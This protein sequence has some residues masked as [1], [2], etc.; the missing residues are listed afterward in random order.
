MT[1]TVA[2]DLLPPAGLYTDEAE[3][4]QL[5]QLIQLFGSQD[6]DVAARSSPQIPGEIVG[7]GIAAAEA[8]VLYAQLS[9]R[10]CRL[11]S[12]IDDLSRG[13][14]PDVVLI[15][16]KY[17]TASLLDAL[18]SVNKANAPGI[19]FGRDSTELMNQVRLRAT[20]ARL[21]PCVGGLRTDVYP[22]LPFKV[23][24]VGSHR[25]FGSKV[26]RTT[27]RKA[28]GQRNGLLTI[29]THTDGIDALLG[30]T[31]MLCPMARQQLRATASKEPSCY[32]NKTCHR[33]PTSLSKVASH[34]AFMAP[35]D[36]RAGVLLWYG[37]LGVLT[38]KSAVDPQWGLALRFLNSCGIGA[39][40]TTWEIVF[41]SA[42]DVGELSERIAEG[43]PVGKAVAE[44]NAS[45]IARRKGLRLC[46]LGD[47]NVSI[48]SNRDAIKSM[49][50]V[51]RGA[52]SIQSRCDLRIPR[53][54]LLGVGFLRAC[55]ELR[56]SSLRGEIARL[57]DRAISACNEYEAA[58]AESR[59]QGSRA[60]SAERKMRRAML[61]YWFRRGSMISKDWS[62]ST[63]SL[64]LINFSVPCFNCGE[65]CKVLLVSFGHAGELRRRC[66]LCAN[67]EIIYDGPEED[68]VS[69]RLTI[70]GDGAL[71][72]E[73]WNPT[74]A[75]SCG[76]M[77]DTPLER[78]R[79]GW[80]WPSD[81]DGRPV[82]KFV[83]PK[84]LPQGPL[85]VSCFMI[86]GTNVSVIRIPTR[87]APA[88]KKRRGSEVT[89][90]DW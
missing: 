55:I 60:E 65:P 67:C 58:I 23:L 8:T 14:P 68:V 11:I 31:L 78:L 6:V 30:Q 42:S 36:I 37:C 87:G 41:G 13:S 22:T 83:L 21:S 47:P 61:R 19:L 33:I 64:K 9:G 59:T 7:I 46:I 81:K 48:T 84:Q 24:N 10:R 77:L 20:A 39:V 66:H 76:V 80:E 82:S 40:V 71:T 44:F 35:E 88:L 89:S 79:K 2:G 43:L 75:W 27:L 18:Y 17:L 45:P 56:R 72:L 63:F 51:I 12:E 38:D 54:S 50:E 90:P 15:E 49:G 74:G 70:E 28:L 4:E 29:H 52:R 62:H 86:A 85:F 73:D 53:R 5:K 32:L 3:R 16:Q 26:G 1:K 57:A 34:K 25:L 69:P